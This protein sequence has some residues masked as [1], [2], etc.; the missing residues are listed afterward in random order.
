MGGNALALRQGDLHPSE[1]FYDLCDKHG[2]VVIDGI[3]VPYT[4]LSEH[5]EFNMSLS[6][7][8][9]DL[10]CRVGHHP[11]SVFCRVSLGI[12][13]GGIVPSGE[14]S[15]SEFLTT[16][17]RIAGAVLSGYDSSASVYPAEVLEKNED[18]ISLPSYKTALEFTSEEDRNLL[19]PVVEAHTSEPE[20]IGDMLSALIK[21]Y[22]L[23]HG[24]SDMIYTASVLS[25]ESFAER[26]LTQRAERDVRIKSSY[27]ALND[28]WPALSASS[29]D[30]FGRLKALHY[31]CRRVFA[32]VLPIL[33]A[34]GCS[35][36]GVISN[37]SLKPFTGKLFCALYD[38]SDRCHKE[39]TLELSCPAGKTAHIEP[40]AF[41]RYM[42]ETPAEYYLFYE[43]S[44]EN[45]TICRKTLRF[46]SPK[47]FRFRNPE[48]RSRISGTGRNYEI[49]LASE[50]YASGV[51]LDF[52]GADISFSDNYFDILPSL[53]VKIFFNTEDYTTA[54]K[55]EEM[56]TVRSV[57]DIGK[58]SDKQDNV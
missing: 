24:F 58:D 49:T 6:E 35:V 33:K 43:L 29:V 40:M 22:R 45:H 8:I 5:P 15:V 7:R 20:R 44:D 21:Q 4:N 9:S 3:T 39:I 28:S 55:L 25:A 53:P 26:I 57:Y 11:S 31:A 1:H 18:I 46:V 32:P 48:I 37:E 36:V 50:S 54:K 13:E 41:D 2:I 10:Y 42:T 47:A 38:A 56:L 23:P 17:C 14:N 12:E 19:S 34:E 30:Y 27:P 52:T 16:A 51:E